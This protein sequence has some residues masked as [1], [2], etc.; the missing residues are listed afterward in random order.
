MPG[1]IIASATY[2]LVLWLSL[3][4]LKPGLNFI[5]PSSS[6]VLSL[7]DG[8]VTFTVNGVPM[9][10]LG[11]SLMASSLLLFNLVAVPFVLCL[12]L[13]MIMLLLLLW[14]CFLFVGRS[15]AGLGF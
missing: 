4:K 14:F 3:R 11:R 15:M 8:V 7:S 5:S 1:M 2:A 10:L 6:D 13:V 9:V 12:L